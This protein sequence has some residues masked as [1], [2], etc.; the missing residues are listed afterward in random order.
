MDNDELRDRARAELE[1][2]RAEGEIEC[3][4]CGA[5]PDGVLIVRTDL[6]ERE[7]RICN[8]CADKVLRWL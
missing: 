8:R 6:H 7:H 1:A 4:H 2:V 3:Q 5:I